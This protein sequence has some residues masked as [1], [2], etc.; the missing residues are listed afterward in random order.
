MYILIKWIII[1][2]T[3][4]TTFMITQVQKKNI[5]TERK[6]DDTFT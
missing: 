1:H 4:V 2:N 6:F 5:K 3:H